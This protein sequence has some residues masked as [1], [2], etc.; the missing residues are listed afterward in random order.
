MAVRTILPDTTITTAVTGSVSNVVSVPKH[1]NISVVAKFTYGSGGTTV[2]AWLQTS[3]DNG[4]TW[5]DV[6]AFAFTTASA[7]KVSSLRRSIALAAAY[8]PTDG[9]LTD[10]TIKDGLLGGLYRV[11]YTTTGTYAGGTK[12]N[13]TAFT[14]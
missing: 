9:T 2:K 7:T 14:A 4:A 1:S 10:D 5:I 13:V 11:K 3:L 12:L 6:A 8:V